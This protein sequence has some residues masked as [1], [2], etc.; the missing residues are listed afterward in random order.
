MARY[1]IQLAY[2]GTSYF[3]WQVQPNHVSVQAEITNAIST[4]LREDISI[5]GCGRTDTGVHASYYVA[6]FDSNNVLD[7]ESLTQKLNSFFPEDIRVFNI[8]PISEDFNAR[9]DAS[10][11]TYRYF[12]CN[13]KQP[14][15][16]K[17]S[18]QNHFKLDVDA[19][20]TAA[21][22]LVGKQDFTSFS[23]LHTNTTNNI[24]NVTD[25]LWYSH[26]DLLIFEI[27]ANRFLRNM[28]RA[29]VGT[30]VEVGK[31]KIKPEAII[32]ILNAKDR[33]AAGQ[34]VPAKGLFLYDIVYDDMFSLQKPETL[35]AS[36]P[37]N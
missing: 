30:L 23:K 15:I 5:L 16:N 31:S 14:F 24:C 10:S 26:N 12:I 25:A 4:V 7:C 21:K 8:K 11:R 18:W 35:I 29:V 19:M 17:Y 27:S 37:Y 3:G 20:N 2:D 33:C 32:D 22:L 1:V 28:V 13:T 9:F 36:A 6:Q 34:S